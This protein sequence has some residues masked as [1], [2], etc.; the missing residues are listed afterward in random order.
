LADALLAQSSERIAKA[1]SA[2]RF[3][4]FWVRMLRTIETFILFLDANRGNI[5][6]VT[7]GS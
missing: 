3:R 7:F 4:L 5:P 6:R 2:R 1:A